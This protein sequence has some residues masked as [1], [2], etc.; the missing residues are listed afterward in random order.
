MNAYRRITTLI[1]MMFLVLPLTSNG[2]TWQQR[3]WRHIYNCHKTH[4]VQ[5]IQNFSW[6]M[7]QKQ[8]LE[9]FNQGYADNI[10]MQD[11]LYAIFEVE[12]KYVI[13]KNYSVTPNVRLR[14]TTLYIYSCTSNV[15]NDR[16]FIISTKKVLKAGK[17][18]ATVLLPV[19]DKDYRRTK[20]ADGQIVS[21]VGH[22]YTKICVFWNNILLTDIPLSANYYYMDETNAPEPIP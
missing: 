4:F 19:F 1:I 5:Y 8:P 9:D 15:E 6:K 18:Y 12:T 11:S 2:Q 13:R 10:P 21:P 17:L 7:G 3:S 20:K 14:R 16:F 22:H